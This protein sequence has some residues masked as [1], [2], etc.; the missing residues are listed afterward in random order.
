MLRR[1]CKPAYYNSNWWDMVGLYELCSEGVQL[2]VA[3]LL[4]SLVRTLHVFK[5]YFS[6]L[7][8]VEL[9]CFYGIVL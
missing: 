5:T 9:L 4:S 8:L 6:D 2:L 3:M 1:S 7:K